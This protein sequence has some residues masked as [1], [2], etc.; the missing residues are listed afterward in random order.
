MNMTETASPLVMVKN[1][2]VSLAEAQRVQA[3]LRLGVTEED[4]RIGERLIGMRRE[5]V[6]TSSLSLQLADHLMVALWA[7]VRGQNVAR[8]AVVYNLR[9]V[10][11]G[12]TLFLFASFLLW[13]PHF[14][15]FKSVVTQLRYVDYMY[16]LHAN[17]GCNAYMYSSTYIC[18]YAIHTGLSQDNQPC[19]YAVP[20]F[21]CAFSS[22]SSAH[23]RVNF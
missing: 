15:R 23:P 12:D 3:L 14:R 17:R 13:I 4:V 5:N 22:P 9:E 20:K 7:C 8:T 21:P 16:V 19:P 10:L 11:R 1:F 6:S 18:M 2:G